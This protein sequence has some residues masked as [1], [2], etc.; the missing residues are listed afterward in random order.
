M[1]DEL[2]L[3]EA[4]LEDFNAKDASYD[5]WILGYDRDM[6]TTGFEFLHSSHTTPYAAVEAAS[7]LDA[8]TIPKAIKTL[9]TNVCYFT[10][11]VETVVEL[12]DDETE[13]VGT[14]YRKANIPNTIPIAHLHLKSTDYEFTDA[15][16]LRVTCPQ[17][18]HLSNGDYVTVQF[19]DDNNS[20]G[21]FTVLDI[22]RGAGFLEFVN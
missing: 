22:S 1:S 6:T 13:N 11:E 18:R 3:D 7:S 19:L 8:F 21:L 15:G 20:S 5:V 17:L 2:I 4:E 12:D 16:T 10:V 9:P 14:I